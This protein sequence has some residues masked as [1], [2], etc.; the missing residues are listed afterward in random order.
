[1][2]GGSPPKEAAGFVGQPA[3]LLPRTVKLAIR[4][5]IARLDNAPRTTYAGN[6][7]LQPT[8]PRQP[9]RG[10]G[11]HR[12]STLLTLFAVAVLL[13]S[14]A[15]P[16]NTPDA[17]TFA[18]GRVT[19]LQPDTVVATRVNPETFASYLKAVRAAADEYWRSLPGQKPRAPFVYV[20]IK[21]G[22]KS[23]IWCDLPL[24][25]EGDSRATG[26]ERR[27]SKIPAPAVQGG[28]VIVAITPVTP[29]APADGMSVVLPRSWSK[30]MAG[31]KATTVEE[32]VA[33]VWKD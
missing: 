26:L 8:F 15:S 9:V 11:S 19:L 4:S 21:P 25:P 18:G 28:L 32:M 29:D 20:A 14:C 10:S 31:K 2:P 16:R 27:L 13:T 12:I 1:M 5:L 17:P 24:A 33:L 7:K 3:I 6:M 23:R 22:M 30:S